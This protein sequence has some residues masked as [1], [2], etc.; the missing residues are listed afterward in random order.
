MPKNIEKPKGIRP[1]F[2]KIVVERIKEKDITA[3]GLHIPESAKEKPRQGKVLAVGHGAVTLDGSIRPLVI[4]V[5][6]VVLYGK[7]AG[8]D[9]EIEGTEYL[10]LREDD[11]LGVIE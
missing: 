11:V 5:G 9:T 4:K 8:T 2:D 7:Y 3:G 1:I 6:D 10:L